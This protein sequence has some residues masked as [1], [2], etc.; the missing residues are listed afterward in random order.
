M[1]LTASSPRYS[2]HT[3]RHYIS[4]LCFYLCLL[5]GVIDLTEVMDVARFTP[6]ELTAK[7]FKS[8]AP[9][10]TDYLSVHIYVDVIILLFCN[11]IPVKNRHKFLLFFI[12]L[13]DQIYL[14]INDDICV[15]RTKCSKSLHN[16]ESILFGRTRQKRRTSGYCYSSTCLASTIRMITQWIDAC[17]I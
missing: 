10:C 8:L 12:T 6:A 15:I 4:F 14:F 7:K 13:I 9:V 17:S 1:A 11:L 3:C 2:P 16:H 5:Q